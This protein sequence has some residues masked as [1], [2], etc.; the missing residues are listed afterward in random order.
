M[1]LDQQLK[2]QEVLNILVIVALLV[3]LM[4]QLGEEVGQVVLALLMVGQM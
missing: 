2:V 3:L 1:V 4:D